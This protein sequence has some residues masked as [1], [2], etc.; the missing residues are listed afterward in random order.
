M[1]FCCRLFVL[2]LN[3]LLFDF[4]FLHKVVKFLIGRLFGKLELCGIPVLCKYFLKLMFVHWK[5]V[6]MQSSAGFTNKNSIINNAIRTFVLHTVDTVVVKLVVS[7]KVS[8]IRSRLRILGL[9]NVLLEI[10][11]FWWLWSI[12]TFFWLRLSRY[13]L[14]MLSRHCLGRVSQWAYRRPLNS[15]ILCIRLDLLWYTSTLWLRLYRYTLRLDLLW[16]GRLDVR[17]LLG[18]RLCLVNISDRH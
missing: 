10:N 17:L 3:L 2:Y 15:C 18:H 12:R 8:E 11:L 5:V 16:L 6:R 13:R 9:W 1:P 4:V 7:N 14:P